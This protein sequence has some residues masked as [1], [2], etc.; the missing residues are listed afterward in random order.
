MDL[1]KIADRAGLE[2]LAAAA[3]QLTPH[4]LPLFRAA[5]DG[6]IGIVMP[7]RDTGWRFLRQ[8]DDLNRPVVVLVG[9]DDHAS[10]GPSGWKCA[11]RLPEWAGAAIVHSAGGDPEHYR[12]ALVTALGCG[13]LVLVE[14]DT[15]H[16][17][18]WE[19]LFRGRIPVLAIRAP[20]GRLHPEPMPRSS[21]Q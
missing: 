9:D 13:R 4:A 10:T 2:R 16:A 12:F 15:A 7:L 18:E 5:R 19:E 14:T 1:H 17:A 21:M 8:T 6:L 11:R 3:A 20:E